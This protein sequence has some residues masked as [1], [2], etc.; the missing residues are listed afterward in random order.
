MSRISKTLGRF[1][2]AASLLAPAGPALARPVVVEPAVHVGVG[3]NLGFDPWVPGATGP[4]RAGYMWVPG[5]YDRAGFW[6][7]GH[8]RPLMTRAGYAWVPGYWRGREYHEGYWRPE[9]AEHRV[10]VPGYYADRAWIRGHWV[11]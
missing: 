11:G 1:L 10:W 3:L 9:V 8:Y 6:V 5:H 2:L 7:P 4:R